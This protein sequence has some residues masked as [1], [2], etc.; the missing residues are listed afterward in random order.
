M[1]LYIEFLLCLY[2]FK[3]KKKALDTQNES[4]AISTAR[5]ISVRLDN[6]IDLQ[7]LD[8]FKRETDEIVE[9][10]PAQAVWLADPL[11]VPRQSHAKLRTLTRSLSS[12]K[13]TGASEQNG[14][15]PK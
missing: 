6:T 9:H 2:N 12:K 8:I 5:V 11:H 14:S 15:L 10:V 13:H 3:K 4:A 1:S 7:F